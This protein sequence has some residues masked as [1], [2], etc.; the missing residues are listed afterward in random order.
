MGLRKGQTNNR[1]GRT[2]GS[3]NKRT[4][5]WEELRDSLTGELAGHFNTIMKEWA[6][7]EDEDLRYRFVNSFIDIMEFHQP[8]LQRTA[9]S[10]E[11]DVPLV[12]IVID[13]KI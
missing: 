12:Q 6:M 7:S 13:S 9:V 1:K 10:A 3:R 5:E 2:P 8:K 4:Q 11:G